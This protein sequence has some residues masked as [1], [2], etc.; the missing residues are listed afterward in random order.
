MTRSP[1]T[2]T[3]RVM[4]ALLLACILTALGVVAERVLLAPRKVSRIESNTLGRS[5]TIALQ[6]AKLATVLVADGTVEHRTPGGAWDPLKVGASLDIHDEVRTGAASRARLQL[7]TQ[8]TVDMADNTGINVAQLSDTLSHIRLQDGRVVSEVHAASGFLFRVQV[9]G[10]NGQA[11]ARAGRFGVLKRGSS[12]ATFAAEQGSLTVSGAGKNVI[13]EQGEQTIVAD[14]EVPSVPT[15][16]PSSLILKLGRPPPSRM[17]EQQ[18]Q[19]AGVT[20][21]GAVVTVGGNVVAP[22]ESGRFSSMVALVDGPN[23]IR[24][25]VEDAI[26]REQSANLPKVTRDSRPPSVAGK[27]VW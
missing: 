7:G 23:E 13:L 20:S 18:I 16:L 12:P 3:R 22:N 10:N 2:M 17:R 26:G 8:V 9:Q 21:P 14:N 25:H 5:P 11:E 1:H 24:V 4:V 27:V 15:K 19:I 6:T